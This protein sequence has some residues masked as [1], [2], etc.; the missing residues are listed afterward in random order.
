[1]LRL[2]GSAWK[3]RDIVLAQDVSGDKVADLVYRSDASGRLLPRKAIAASG[4]GTDLTSLVSAANSSGGT[5]IYW[6]GTGWLTAAIPH[7]LGAPDANGDGNP[8]RVDGPLRRHGPLLRRRPGRHD[9][10]GD[11]D[12]RAK[13]L[14]EDPHRRRLSAP[15][16]PLRAPFSDLARESGA[17]FDASQAAQ[18]I[19]LVRKA[20]HVTE[21]AMD[22]ILESRRPNRHLTRLQLAPLPGGV[23]RPERRSRRYC[24]SSGSWS[25]QTCQPSI[26]MRYTEVIAHSGSHSSEHLPDLVLSLCRG[27]H[28]FAWF[29][30][31][32][33]EAFDLAVDLV[34]GLVDDTRSPEYFFW[35]DHLCFGISIAMRVLR[36]L[37]CVTV[38]L[39]HAAFPHDVQVAVECG[40]ELPSIPVEFHVAGAPQRT[41]LAD[42]L[43]VS[44]ELYFQALRSF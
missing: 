19:S 39:L 27:L 33:F 43:M 40:G 6:T 2:S 12:Y 9:R 4:G 14:V 21:Q 22:R 1:M 26:F 17:L 5:D 24:R 38:G 32:A 13:L 44:N 18:Q 3:E 30:G 41:V 28:R 10:L 8:R 7:V 35:G 15:A 25:T 29:G 31:T 16:P 20:R 23:P 11:R 36:P 34:Q 42:L 37:E